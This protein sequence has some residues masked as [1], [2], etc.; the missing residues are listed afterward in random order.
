MLFLFDTEN[1]CL[2]RPCFGKVLYREMGQ[3]PLQL[4]LRTSI[5][6]RVVSCSVMAQAFTVDLIISVICIQCCTKIINNQVFEYNSPL[7]VASKV[8]QLTPRCDPY[9]RSIRFF[10]LNVSRY[11]QYPRLVSYSLKCIPFF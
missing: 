5:I 2:K 10:A 1:A 9:S 3:T 6:V 11:K 4:S 8:D 7:L